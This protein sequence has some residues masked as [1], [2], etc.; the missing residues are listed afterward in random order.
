MKRTIIESPYRA[1]DS[2]QQ[3]LYTAYS[4]RAVGDSIARGEAPIA[5]HRWYTLFLDDSVDP[6]RKLGIA[7]SL[8]WIETA[9]LLAVYADH[10][11]SGGMFQGIQHA[12]QHGIPVEVRYLFSAGHRHR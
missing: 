1:V 5:F 7:M 6:Q 2:K 11:I 12:T 9:E 3:K 4:R 8:R 10:G